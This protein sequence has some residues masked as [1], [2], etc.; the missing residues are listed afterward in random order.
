MRASHRVILRGL[1]HDSVPVPRFGSR[2]RRL[3]AN[4]T[5]VR[6]FSYS[7]PV[8]FPP[9]ATF[10]GCASGVVSRRAPQSSYAR[11]LN[12][13]PL[14]HA[15]LPCFWQAQ[16]QP[17]TIL[18]VATRRTRQTRPRKLSPGVYDAVCVSEAS[19]PGPRLASQMHSVADCPARG[20]LEVTPHTRA[21]RLALLIAPFASEREVCDP[22][23]RP[24]G[25]SPCH[26]D[27]DSASA[28]SHPGTLGGVLTPRHHQLPPRWRY[29]QRWTPLRQQCRHALA[30]DV[31]EP[32]RSPRIGG[33][34]L[35]SR[36]HAAYSGGG[37]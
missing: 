13:G 10:G 18:S 23:L 32:C 29:H 35:R 22:P 6:H 20:H 16:N 1:R 7:A 12:D 34:A 3:S 33:A 9:T 26:D 11:Q 14:H 17:S 36:M 25:S 24:P 37:S 5:G 27:A 4:A 8:Q 28:T 21:L 2:Q 15:V 30:W 31:H 19:N